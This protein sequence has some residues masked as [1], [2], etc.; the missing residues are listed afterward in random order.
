MDLSLDA[1]LAKAQLYRLDIVYN[2][3]SQK[4][5]NYTEILGKT[6]VTGKENALFGDITTS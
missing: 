1:H 6:F 3:V 2:S 5:R 4:P